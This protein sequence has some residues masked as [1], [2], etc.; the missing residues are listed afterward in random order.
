MLRIHK[1]VSVI[2]AGVLKMHKQGGG[3][4][5]GALGI[6]LSWFAGYLVGRGRGMGKNKIKKHHAPPPPPFHQHCVDFF[7]LS[8]AN[9]IEATYQ[10]AQTVQ[11][12]VIYSRKQML[13]F[14]PVTT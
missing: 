3:E 2:L 12:F 4:T 7:K 14:A 5:E 1:F 11:W 9:M 6:I 10:K 13:Q 8:I